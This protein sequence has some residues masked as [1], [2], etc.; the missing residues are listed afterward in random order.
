MYSELLRVDDPVTTG[1]EH[2]HVANYGDAIRLELLNWH[3]V[4]CLH[5][6]LA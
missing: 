1:A 4:M 6:T 5:A 2:S 3:L